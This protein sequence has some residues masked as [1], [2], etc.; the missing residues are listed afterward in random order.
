MPRGLF[1]RLTG[2]DGAPTCR[3]ETATGRAEFV[4]EPTFAHESRAAI[5][6]ELFTRVAVELEAAGSPIELRASRATRLVSDDGAFEPDE[7]L[8]IGS[9][10]IAAA[11]RVGGWLDVRRGHPVPDLVIEIDRST[12]STRKLAPYFR[13]GVREVWTWSR[14]DGAAIWTPG[15]QAS[16]PVSRTSA[17]RVLPGVTRDALDELFGLPSRSARLP[18]MRQ[19][20]RGVASGLDARDAEASV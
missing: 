14:G 18:V 1:D 20:A 16:T 11:E 4:A 3:Y 17:S 13:M 6:G 12:R 7:G 15:G 10:K 8:F 2:H 5:A 9:E 19:L